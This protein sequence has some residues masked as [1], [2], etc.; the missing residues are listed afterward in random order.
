VTGPGSRFRALEARLHVHDLARALQF[1]VGVLG[2]RVTSV[3]PDTVAPIFAMLARDH[4]YLQLGG[5]GGTRAVETPSTCTLWLDV[6]DA[7]GLWEQLRTMTTIEWGPQVF[8]YGRREFA[9]R[10]PD[11]N[12]LVFSEE[13]SD[14][15][16]CEPNR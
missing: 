2:F 15:P 3:F 14:P 12:L 6:T 16:S 8:F 1:Y 11:G 7:Q 10:D 5:A 9:V 13:T 4:V